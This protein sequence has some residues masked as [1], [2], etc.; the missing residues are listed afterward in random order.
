M[1]VTLTHTKSMANDF[2][3]EFVEDWDWFVKRHIDI[4]N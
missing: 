3:K 1:A 2:S 4:W